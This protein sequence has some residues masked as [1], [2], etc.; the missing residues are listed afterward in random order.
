MANRQKLNDNQSLS[1]LAECRP[2]TVSYLKVHA[3]PVIYQHR[4]V[5][6]A[7]ALLLLLAA[8]QSSPLSPY[9]QQPQYQL[10]AVAGSPFLH[11]VVEKIQKNSSVRVLHV[12]IEGDGRP[13]WSRYQVANDPTPRKLI[14][15][16]LMALDPT[17]AVYLGR[18]CYFALND[19]LCEPKWWTQ[20]RYHQHVVSSMNAVL[21]K[22]LDGY[23]NDYS[24][25][26]LIGHSGGAAVAMLMAA[27][28]NDIQA[29]V[30]LAGNLDVEAWALHHQYSPLTESLNPLDFPLASSVKQLHFVGE[31]DQVIPAKIIQQ[32][33]KQLGGSVTVLPR[34]DHNCCWQRHWP[35]IL[36][37]L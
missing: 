32:S 29:V 9:S 11:Q 12:Y 16:K 23:A 27:Q 30:T 37:S 31:D 15:L 25:I 10:S 1:P 17:P 3:R 6:A 8:C 36:Q 7:M 18:P 26:R 5:V 34:V 24:V 20:S 21:D 33:V 14:M 4:T 2:R 13:W 35:R 22:V 19:P 28:R